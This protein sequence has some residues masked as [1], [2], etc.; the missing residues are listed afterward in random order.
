MKGLLNAVLA[1]TMCASPLVAQQTIPPA[2][3]TIGA[4]GGGGGGIAIP[5]GRWSDFH[6]A[7]Y[8][9]SGLVDFSAAEQP[10][11]FRAE[12]SYQRYDR[13]NS[14]PTGVGNKNV[15]ALTVNLL[16]RTPAAASSGYAIGGI[17]VYRVTDEGTRPGINAGAGL[18][19]P[20]TFFIGI[21]DVRI[22]WVLS[23]GRP[24]LS[25]PITLGAR[26]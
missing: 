11:S 24:G 5:I 9:L 21:A 20:L 8:T 2:A 6:G 15:V 1:A 12:L 4:S 10:Y 14:T 13:K 16:A 26:F 7:G 18:E 17:G 23:E 3:P 22:H 19:V 25:I